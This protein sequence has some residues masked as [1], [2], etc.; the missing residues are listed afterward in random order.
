MS[1]L[2]IISKEVLLFLQCHEWLRGVFPSPFWSI[3]HWK[4]GLLITPVFLWVH[5][6]RLLEVCR[7]LMDCS[8]TVWSLSCRLFQLFFVWCC[9]SGGWFWQS[10]CTFSLFS[11]GVF[12]HMQ[13]PH[14][15]LV[16]LLI[17]HPL[18]LDLDECWLK[19]EQNKSITWQHLYWEVGFTLV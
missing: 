12:F 1:W 19:A 15:A 2:P 4:W 7:G 10:L 14:T 6:A 17:S 11:S 3:E 9:T 13:I 18:Q 8:S 16:V 5:Y